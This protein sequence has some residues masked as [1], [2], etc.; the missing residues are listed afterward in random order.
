MSRP[1]SLGRKMLEHAFKEWAAICDALGDGRQGL[2]LRKGGI[3]EH[4]GEFTPDYTRF[5]LYPTYTHQQEQGIK[6]EANR[7]RTSRHT[8]SFQ[9]KVLLR[10]FAEVTVT[11]YVGEWDILRSLDRW[12]CWTPET[13]LKRFQYRDPGMYILGVR[14]Y[15]VPRPFQ[16]LETDSYR[17]CRSWVELESAKPTDGAKPV[18]DDSTYESWVAQWS[19]LLDRDGTAA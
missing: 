4:N 7:P 14:V 11:A 15:A 9:G 18:V 10:H 13:V 2:I 19:A 8:D 3:S 16:V 6:S 5:W 1:R 12:H 17:G